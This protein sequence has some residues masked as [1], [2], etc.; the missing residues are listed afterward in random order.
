MGALRTNYF[1]AKS[2]NGIFLLTTSLGTETQSKPI[3]YYDCL[4]GAPSSM[5]SSVVRCDAA[6]RF[7]VE[8]SSIL[9]ESYKPL[10]TGAAVDAGTNS[11]YSL[12]AVLSQTYG[13]KDLAGL[14]RRMNRSIDIGA[15]EYDWR[16]AFG[17]ALAKGLEIEDMSA[18]VTTNGTGLSMS[19][20]D[21]IV[22]RFGRDRSDVGT[23]SFSAAIDGAGALHVFDGGTNLIYEIDS[24]AATDVYSVMTASQLSLTFV[25]RGDGMATLSDFAKPRQGM[26]LIVR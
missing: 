9:D 25:F 19:T 17:N 5:T 3:D 23:Y 4:L 13:D 20:N 21:R 1:E 26:L 8:K 24:S 7:S 6:C 2:Y 12:P 10:G 15:Y 18:G 16:P 14:P 22:L 11:Y